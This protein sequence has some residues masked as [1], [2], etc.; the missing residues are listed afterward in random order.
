MAEGRR[1]ATSQRRGGD[2]GQ[3][4]SSGSGPARPGG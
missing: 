2:G 3:A 1:L 4:P